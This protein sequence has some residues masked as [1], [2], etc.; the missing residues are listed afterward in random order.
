MPDTPDRFDEVDRIDAYLDGTLSEAASAD[1]RQWIEANAANAQVFAERAVLH[2]Q[3]HGIQKRKKLES[4][5]DPQLV[6]KELLAMEQGSQPVSPRDL[7]DDARRLGEAAAFKHQQD[8]RQTDVVGLIGF[9]LKLAIQSR[10]AMIAGVAAVLVL[11]LVIVFSSGDDRPGPIADQV[12]NNSEPGVVGSDRPTIDPVIAALTAEHDAV[13]DRRPGESLS[14]G[15]RFTLI[16]GFAEVTMKRGGVVLLEAPC[17]IELIHDN[18]IRLD[19]GRLV[20]IVE[21][22]RAQGFLVRTPQIDVVDLGTRFGVEADPTSDHSAV[23]VIE[24]LVEVSA[25][26]T[27]SGQPSVVRLEAE[28]GLLARTGQ[29]LAMAEIDPMRFVTDPAVW[30]YMIKTDETAKFLGLD[31]P[32]SLMP[33]ALESSERMHV[34]LEQTGVEVVKGVAAGITKPGTYRSF[35]GPGDPVAYAGQVDSYLVHLDPVGKGQSVTLSGEF[36][37]PRPIVA[38]LV[39]GRQLIKTDALFANP[40]T[41]LYRQ[42]DMPF[43]LDGTDITLEADQTDELVLSEDRRTLRYRLFALEPFDEFRVLIEAADQEP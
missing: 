27:D 20:G 18:A 33:A 2:H 43:G 36:T 37:F 38:V 29:G 10:P 35:A 30:P 34:V 9:C 32:A 6:L 8:R 3:I 42:P 22:E 17:T 7:L 11:T 16:E 39:N 12:D 15:Q 24:G 4:L 40:G 26:E 28:Q 19:R 23:S 31:R 41:E 25:I 1:L 14:A 13:W 21:S 5:H